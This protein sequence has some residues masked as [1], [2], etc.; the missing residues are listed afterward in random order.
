MLRRWRVVGR[1]SAASANGA[2]GDCGI[3]S[4]YGV[5]AGR[6]EAETRYGGII[7]PRVRV[8]FAMRFLRSSVGD[9]KTG[10]VGVAAGDAVGVGVPGVGVSIPL[11]VDSAGELGGRTTIGWGTAFSRRTSGRGSSFDPRPF[12]DDDTVDLNFMEA[13][14]AKVFTFTPVPVSSFS[15]IVSDTT[16]LAPSADVKTN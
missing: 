15:G 3:T 12:V 5:A 1:M 10:V 4:A 8:S 14:F 6:L 2:L 7:S 9:G 13:F 16:E 11:V